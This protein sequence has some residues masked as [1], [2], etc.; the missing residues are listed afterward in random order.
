MNEK[1]EKIASLLEESISVKRK[2]LESGIEPVCR[3]V[4]IIVDSLKAGGKVLLF[5]NG[6]SAADAQHLAAEFV[7]RFLIERKAL[8]AIAITTDSSILTCIG[9]DRD[10]NE[11]FSRQIEA[12]GTP[13]DVAFGITTSGRSPNVIHALERA[14]EK[15]LSTI[16]LIGENMGSIEHCSDVVIKVPSSHTPRIQEAHITIGHIICHL[17]EEELFKPNE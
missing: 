8:P 7:N 4:E 11:I 3:A 1:K 6:G 17:A 10:Y 5:G 9:N 2:L 12:L 15:G 14:K 16:S 13:G